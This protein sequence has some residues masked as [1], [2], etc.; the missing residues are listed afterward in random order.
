[1]TQ[2][3][4]EFVAMVASAFA[5]A[6]SIRVYLLVSKLKRDREGRRGRIEMRMAPMMLP[7]GKDFEDCA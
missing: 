3:Q 7:T 4:M 6:G 1:M 2:E 5:L